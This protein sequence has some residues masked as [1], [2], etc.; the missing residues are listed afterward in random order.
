MVTGA[1]VGVAAVVVV[2]ARAVVVV[3]A[4]R[5]V[6]VNRVVVA[7]T[8]VVGDFVVVAATVVVGELVVVD[9]IVEVTTGPLTILLGGVEPLPPIA[10]AAVATTTT[11]AIGET[12]FAHSGHPMNF[13]APALAAR[14]TPDPP[15]V[16]L[17]GGGGGGGI[18]DSGMARP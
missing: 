5:V 14:V 7:A 15:G 13:A 6:V 3:V 17:L 18:T 10:L 8:V 9:A 1:V 16:P 2:V 12:T 11:A 4:V